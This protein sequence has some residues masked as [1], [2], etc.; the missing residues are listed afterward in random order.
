MAQRFGRPRRSTRSTGLITL[1]TQE[2]T[3]RPVAEQLQAVMVNIWKPELKLP[4]S[5]SAILIGPD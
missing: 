3:Y 1:F 4:E 2:I 5:V